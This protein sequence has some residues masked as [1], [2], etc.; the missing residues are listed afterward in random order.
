MQPSSLKLTSV[1]L[2][3]TFAA[4]MATEMSQYGI[5]VTTTVVPAVA[6]GF[7][8]LGRKTA[9]RITRNARDL[10]AL[11]NGAC[12]ECYFVT[13][14]EVT[15][16]PRCTTL[17]CKNCESGFRLWVRLRRFMIGRQSRNRLVVEHLG[18]IVLADYKDAS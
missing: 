1:C 10:D 18:K 4:G 12:P 14:G 11:R 13:I 17:Y 9:S 15:S 5:L 2:I 16:T 7:W 6:T 3:S 8:W